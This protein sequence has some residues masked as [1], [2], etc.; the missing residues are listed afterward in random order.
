[1][2]GPHRRGSRSRNPADDCDGARRR[3]FPITA[4]RCF[5]GI[6][7]DPGGRLCSRAVA[8]CDREM[9]ARPGLYGS[10]EQDR[11]VPSKTPTAKLLNPRKKWNSVGADSEVS[12]GYTG[13]S[14]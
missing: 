3:R 6:I 14:T 10:S 5:H 7:A 8:S 2:A 4:D 12:H 9:G 11:I 1:V 13:F